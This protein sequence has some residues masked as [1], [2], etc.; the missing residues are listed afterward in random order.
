M[1][2]EKDFNNIPDLS[3][4]GIRELPTF[5]VEADF[6][7]SLKTYKARVL[8]DGGYKSFLDSFFDSTDAMRRTNARIVMLASG[9][10]NWNQDIAKLIYSRKPDECIRVADIIFEKT[11]EFMKQK[12]DEADKAEKN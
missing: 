5:D 1:S 8:D 9:M 4:L 6:D 10:D 3:K 7:G 11:V 2:E 12:K